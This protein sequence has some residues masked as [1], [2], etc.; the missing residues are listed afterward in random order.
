MGAS[1]RS[2]R[3]A[4]VCLSCE[5]VFVKLAEHA[6]AIRLRKELGWPMNKIAS[7]LHVAKSTVSLWV[8]DVP[9]TPDQVER[10]KQQ[11]PAFNAQ[12]RGQNRRR[13]QARTIRMGYQQEGRE[14]AR[15]HD[16]LHAQGCMLFWAEGSRRRNSVILTNSYPDMLAFFLRFLRTC[17]GVSDRRIRLSCNCFLNNGLSR[18]Q[19]ESYWLDYLELPRE[20]LCKTIINRLSRASGGTKRTLPYGT[21]R[22]TVH[23]T[24]IV[25]SIYGAIQEYADFN[26]SA[27]LDRL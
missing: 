8:R 6:E 21:A 18:T 9:V 22:V 4:L 23:S 24:E 19:I 13:E 10:L 1:C 16:P 20:A 17:Y 2:L 27:W 25:Q 5:L 11:N 26:R 12:L 14:R 15:N 7:E 3:P